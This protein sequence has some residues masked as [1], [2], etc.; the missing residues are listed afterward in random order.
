[1]SRV[2]G[3]RYLS[4]DCVIRTRARAEAVLASINES[5]TRIDRR[6]AAPYPAGPFFRK[7]FRALKS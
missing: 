6:Y 4:E 1:M 7:V 3:A 5:D 2:D